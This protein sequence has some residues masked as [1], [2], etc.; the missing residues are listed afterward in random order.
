MSNLL[1]LSNVVCQWVD[2]NITYCVFVF[3]L[4]LLLFCIRW[5]APYYRGVSHRTTWSQTWNRAKPIPSLNIREITLNNDKRRVF[6]MFH[7]RL[8]ICQTKHTVNVVIVIVII[9]RRI[10]LSCHW[11][12]SLDT[13]THTYLSSC[14]PDSISVMFRVKR[15]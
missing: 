11:L 13:G 5:Q 14:Q 1:S 10:Q 3:F 7:I 15:Y 2:N 4:V 8:Y 12:Q 6:I 9:F